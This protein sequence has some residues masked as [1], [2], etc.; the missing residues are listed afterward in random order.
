MKYAEYFTNIMTYTETCG[1]FAI[2]KYDAIRRLFNN[3]P[4][5]T[6]EL[7]KIKAANQPC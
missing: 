1:K 6:T 7:D 3:N 4:Y 2:N 5:T